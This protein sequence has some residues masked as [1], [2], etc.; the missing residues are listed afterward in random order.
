MPVG[1]ILAKKSISLSIKK[2]KARPGP[3]FIMT[4]MDTGS[5]PKTNDRLYPGLQ[6]N[7]KVM[8]IKSLSAMIA[9]KHLKCLI[10]WPT[11]SKKSAWAKI[12]NNW[13]SP[14][15]SLLETRKSNWRV[16]LCISRNL[17]ACKH[18][19]TKNSRPLRTPIDR[20]W[21]SFRNASN[22][23]RSRYQ[24][25]PDVPLVGCCLLC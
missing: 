11:Q 22:A 6:P 12:S 10:I 2:K 7:G 20:H 25:G 16:S 23:G 24:M 18:H 3:L 19:D 5:I 14:L 4:K 21:R 15:N 8:K 1:S 13:T 9:M 17:T